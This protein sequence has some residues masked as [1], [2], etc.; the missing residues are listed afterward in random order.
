MS[1][2]KKKD[3]YLVTDYRIPFNELLEKTESALKGGVTIVQYRA[4]NMSTKDMCYEALK[5]RELC[6]RYNALFL[7][8][9][10]IDVALAVK[11]HGVHIGQDDMPLSLARKILPKDSVIGVTVHN[12]EE[13]IKAI[14]EGADNLGVGALFLTNSKDDATLMSMETLKEIKSVSNIPLYGIGGINTDNL[15]EEHLELLDGVAVISA[16][17]KASDVYEKSKEFLK[18]LNK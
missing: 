6:E 10:R 1:N 9:D 15:K 7:V 11:S 16:L 4:K 14:E 8:N 5:L 2:S 12:K 3:L 13:A 18:I 17:L